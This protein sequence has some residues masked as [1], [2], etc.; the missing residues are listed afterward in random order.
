MQVKIPQE[1]LNKI[2]V[3]TAKSVIVQKVR[4]A[5]RNH[6]FEEFNNQIGNIINNTVIQKGG[7]DV[8]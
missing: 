6:I 5:E 3:R 4:E 8:I 1:M 7:S 2:A